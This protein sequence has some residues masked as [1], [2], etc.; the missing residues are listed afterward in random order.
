MNSKNPVVNFE[1]TK[2][3]FSAE[4]FVNEAPITGNNFM[5]LVRSGFYNNLTFHRVITGF[6]AQGGDPKGDGSGGSNETIA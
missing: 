6:M 2:G 4:I 3:N 5:K 1:T